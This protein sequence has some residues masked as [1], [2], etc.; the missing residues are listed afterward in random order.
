MVALMLPWAG[1]A[2]SAEG[3]APAGSAAGGPPAWISSYSPDPDAYI[4]IGRA[5]KRGHPE[6]YR[7]LAQ[8]QALAHISREISVHVEAANQSTWKES[9][10]VRDDAFIQRI[11]TS[12]RNTLTGYRLAG[13]YETADAFWALYV[14]DKEAYLSSRKES[15]LRFATWLAGEAD[16]IESDLDDLR[17]QAAADRFT[18]LG[19]AYDSACAIGPFPGTRPASM[20]ARF[21]TVSTRVRA[22][23]AAAD[24]ILRPSAW[25]FSLV[26]RNPEANFAEVLLRSRDGNREWSGPF[27]LS[28]T[29]VRY[30]GK[31]CRVETDRNGRFDLRRPFL[32]CGLEPGR[33]RIVWRGPNRDAAH[34][35]T[36]EADAAHSLR[37]ETD[38][39]WKPAE[40]IL[41][42]RSEDTRIPE[43]TL[44]RLRESISASRGKAYRISRSAAS[45]P[46]P[47][48]E[49]VLDVRVKAMTLDSL[50]GMHFASV[51][52][53]V[54]LPGTESAVEVGGESGHA[55]PERARGLAILDF[56]KRLERMPAPD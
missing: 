52:A 10:K 9:G 42:F 24:M 44:E 54:T 29:N 39:S 53:D 37:A 35:V 27:S 17:L 40:A 38:V 15:E 32:E 23:S 51:R 20:H 4:G 21:R 25:S 41:R 31:A 6:D 3:A 45:G 8:A 48:G 1:P 16:A 43:A 55:D 22:A 28:L 18:R 13:T 30:P 56:L 7:D 49:A 14:L 2:P 50:E 36:A 12:T 26:P 47:S 11:A 34:S 33:W 19:R 5:D 46:S